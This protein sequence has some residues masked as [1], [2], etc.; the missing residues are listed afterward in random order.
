MFSR[1]VDMEDPELQASVERIKDRAL[2]TWGWFLCVLVTLSAIAMDWHLRHSIG[3]I[4]GATLVAYLIAWPL[5]VGIFRRRSRL[6]SGQLFIGFYFLLL[7]AI[8]AFG[9]LAHAN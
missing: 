9:P 4:T 3:K 2:W 8:N 6:S 7:L 5:N 1:G